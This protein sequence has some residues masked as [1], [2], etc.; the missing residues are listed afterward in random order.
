MSSEDNSAI[1][2]AISNVQVLDQR[3][4]EEKDQSREACFFYPSH[5]QGEPVIFPGQ[6]DDNI[7]VQT[8]FDMERVNSYI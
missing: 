3:Y 8:N 1:N 4:Y 2:V 5:I 7:A 6:C